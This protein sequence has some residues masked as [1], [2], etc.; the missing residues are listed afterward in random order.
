[1]KSSSCL[2]LIV[3]IF[4]TSTLPSFAQEDPQAKTPPLIEFRRASFEA[5]DG[6]K[7]AELY[8]YEAFVF[9]G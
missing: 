6:W 3:A 1:M 5:N 9:R 7:E 2:A 4:W 8:T